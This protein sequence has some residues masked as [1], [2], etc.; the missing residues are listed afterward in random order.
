V[1][2]SLN[3]DQTQCIS[4]ISEAKYIKPCLKK[5][6]NYKKELNKKPNIHTQLVHHD[7]PN[8]FG[9]WIESHMIQGS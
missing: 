2:K 1:I 5:M 3:K 7:K 9:L 6:K 8:F 4:A